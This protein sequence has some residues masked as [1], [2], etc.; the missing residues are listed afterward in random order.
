V[1]EL[2]CQAR[3]PTFNKNL[4]CPSTAEAANAFPDGRTPAANGAL[5]PPKPCRQQ[6]TTLRVA[7]LPLICTI[8]K[9]ADFTESIRKQ[10]RNAYIK[11]IL[12][13]EPIWRYTLNL[14]PTLD[15]RRHAQRLAEESARV[16]SDLDRYGVAQTSLEAI[17][18]D[19]ELLGRLQT[20]ARQL[21]EAKAEVIRKQQEALASDKD[22]GNGE[23]E[24]SFVV[25]MFDH[26]RP[27]IE[28]DGLLAQLLLNP[29]VKGVAD[30]YYGLRTK[31]ADINIWRNLP[32]GRDPIAS[33][34]WHRDLLTDHLMLK[35]FL[36]LEDVDEGAGP[37]SYVK[38]THTK[39][40]RH[41]SPNTF[42]FDGYNYRASDD[43]MAK[44][45]T[46]EERPVFVAP[47]GAIVF[48]DTSGWHRGGFAVTKSRFV[49][50]ALFQSRAALPDR[51]LG[52]P[53]GLDLSKAPTDL[54]FDRK[55][56]SA[57]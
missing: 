54:L 34:L 6:L 4:C 17:T 28:P 39:G 53:K 1:Q 41:W 26:S 33:Q 55:T 44:S 3:L 10:A 36:Y 37:F 15:Y 18:G 45:T 21:E 35:M 30:H 7:F 13:V 46:E 40:R 47:A 52:V 42:T 56:A 48:A 12:N 23:K 27:V 29:N 16:A 43:D 5:P 20:H 14:G 2:E 38:G 32:T 31:V 24:K 22:L 9:V 8:E 51:A 57:A 50:Q 19:S 49:V 11:G 25:T